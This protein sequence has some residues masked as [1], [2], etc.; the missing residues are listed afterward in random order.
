LSGTPQKDRAKNATGGLLRRIG[1]RGVLVIKDVTSVISMSR[2]RRAE[3]LAALREVYDG[4]WQRELGV[5]GGKV[6]TWTGR[7]AV[8]GAVTT[9][10]DTAHSVISLMGDRFVLIRLDSRSGRAA[11]GRRTVANTGDEIAMRAEL[12]AAVVG[13]LDG[14]DPNRDLSLTK[15]ETEHLLAAADVVTLAR[16][17]VEYDGQGNVIDAHAPEMPTR[18]LRQLQQ[19]VRGGIALGMDR[20]R[21]MRLAI[22]CARD[23]MPPIRLAIIDD[24]ANYPDSRPGDIRPRVDLPWRTVDRQC[25]ALHMLGVTIC[26]EEKISNPWGSKDKTVWRYSLADKINSEA[27]KPSPEMA[28]PSSTLSSRGDQTIFNDRDVQAP[29]A[30]SGDASA[31]VGDD[32]WLPFDR[33][34]ATIEEAETMIRLIFGTEAVRGAT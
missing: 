10:W 13:A 34:P 18:Y 31:Q 11:A 8:I 28:L 12:A 15:D 19:I 7:I 14:L 30:K 6:L 9:A 4:Y 22:R 33:P 3:V 21:A 24:L 20:G 23:T 5:D 29:L 26:N 1:E 27:L 16:T 17:A 25:Q 2:D 32:D